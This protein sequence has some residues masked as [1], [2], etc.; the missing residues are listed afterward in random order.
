MRRLPQTTLI[1]DACSAKDGSSHAATDDSRTMF[2]C[3]AHPRFGPL[4]PGGRG[5]LQNVCRV[6]LIDRGHMDF[7]DVVTNY[8][9]A[10]ETIDAGADVGAANPRT[11]V[12][13][14][15]GVKSLSEPQ[16]LAAVDAWWGDNQPGDFTNPAISRLGIRYPTMETVTRCDHVFTTDGQEVEPEWAIE[17]KRAQLVGDNGKRNDYLTSKVLSPFLKDRSILHDV[18]RLRAYPLA[19]KHAVV[20]YGFNYNLDT[21]AEARKRFP[22]EAER[23]A[24][25]EEVCRGNGG[26]LSLKPLLDFAES[27]LYVRGLIPGP[28][29]QASFEAWA[30]PCGGQGVVFGWEVRRPELEEGFDPRHPW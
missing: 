4:N 16:A 9:L 30:H 17:W 13:Y 22:Q 25:I 20:G 12:I 5:L 29:S 2:Q 15:P 6:D 26:E 27:I 3:P 23:I 11:G 7:E 10:L 18:L 19:R 24:N 28:R 14:K 1:R 8:A 21:C